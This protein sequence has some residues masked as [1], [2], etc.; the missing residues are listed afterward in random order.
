MLIVTL[1]SVVATVFL[2]III[3]KGFFPEEDTGMIF[4]STEA[5]EDISFKAMA[6]LQKEAD[7]VVNADPAVEVFNSFIGGGSLNQ[8]RM[9]IAL[10]PYG[11]RPPVGVVIQRLRKKLSKIAGINAFLRPVQ[12]I[13]VGGHL[14]KSQYQL[15]LQGTEFSEVEQYAPMLEA[16]NGTR[17][18]GCRT[19][20]AICRSRSRKPLS[21]SIGK[22]RRHWASASDDIRRTLYSAFGQRQVATI[23]TPS[24]SYEV[25]LELAPQFRDDVRSISSLYV[26]TS[27]NNLVPL[28]EVATVSHRAAPVSVDHQATLPSVLL[29]FNLAPGTSL[30]QA[31]QKINDAERDMHLPA[32][33]TTSFQG[34][35]QVFT[36]S[37]KGQGI[38]LLAAIFVIYVVLGILYESFVHPI[39]ILSGLPAAGFGALITLMLFQALGQDWATLNVI[40]I[41]GLV[42]LIGIVKKNAIMM[43]DFALE[44]QRNEGASR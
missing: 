8:G 21:T 28:S 30:G 3:N 1:G 39:T 26:P 14:S 11:Q 5:A 40:A 13:N 27:N 9:F 37:L 17:S 6:E 32:T 16:A 36:D 41:I 43:I 35:A 4:G 33:L 44:R 24:N 15:V 29:S 25:I 18:R 12:N 10:K 2:F 20:P 34:T 23:Y 7:A 38:L 22:R 19:S 31:V 42:M